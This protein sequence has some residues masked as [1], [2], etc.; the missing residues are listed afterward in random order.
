M[1]ELDI[2]SGYEQEV[3]ESAEKIWKQTREESG[4]ET[5]L[6]NT[7]KENEN[8]FLFFGVFKSQEDFDIHVQKEYISAFKTTL[9]GKVIGDG[10]KVTFLNQFKD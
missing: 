6:F 7:K 8:S 5:F 3:K 4:C 1:A 2:L 10:L 9:Y